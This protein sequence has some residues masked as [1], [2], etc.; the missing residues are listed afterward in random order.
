[1]PEPSLGMVLGKFMPPHRGHQVLIDFA[2]AYVDRLVVQVC[3]LEREPIP[4]SLRYRWMQEAF[5]TAEVVHHTD[6]IPSYPHECPDRFYDI[7]RESLLKRMDRAPDYVFAGED[8]GFPL[9]EAL[10]AK[11]IPMPR[12]ATAF[13][14]AATAIRQDPLGCWDWILPQARPYFLKRVAIVGPESVGKSTLSERLAAHFGTV[15]VPEYGRIYTDAYGMDLT[16]SDFEAIARGHRAL[17]DSLAPNA[18]GVLIC[19]TEAVV[20]KTW[21]RYLL[22]AVPP[23]VEAYACEPRYDLYLLLPPTMPWFQDGT[24]VQEDLRVRQWFFECCAN[25]LQGR[26][27]VVLD[28]DWDAR[29]EQAVQEVNCLVSGE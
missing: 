20:T 1:M 17:E 13:P 11:F 12:Q 16:P 29:F 23:L 27:T 8:Y 5:P 14:C 6:E 22:D 24:R 7:W 28:G 18:R 3:T 19:D 26:H 4:G 15:H 21:S 25:D 10:G 2:R 9:G